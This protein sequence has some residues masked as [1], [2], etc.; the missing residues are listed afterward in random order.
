MTNLN[1][2]L[3]GAYASFGFAVDRIATS[4]ELRELFRTRLSVEHASTTDDELGR[5]LLNLRKRGK[6]SR[7]QT[8]RA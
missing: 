2:A 5:R 3:I 8:W 7:A 4:S 1:D 6:L